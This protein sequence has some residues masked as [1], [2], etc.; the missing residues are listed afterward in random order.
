M[1]K[2]QQMTARG[3]DVSKSAWDKVSE[4]LQLIFFEDQKKVFVSSCPTAV[5]KKIETISRDWPDLQDSAA[6]TKRLLMSRQQ[7][8][9]CESTLHS[10]QDQDHQKSWESW[11]TCMFWF[12]QI[13]NLFREDAVLEKRH[14]PGSTEL[15][16]PLYPYPRRTWALRD[17]SSSTRRSP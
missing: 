13:S 1:K 17:S 7:Y 8:R 5:S 15:K 9:V 12:L 10:M 3:S 2:L 16:R 14:G 11:K 6:W 4:L